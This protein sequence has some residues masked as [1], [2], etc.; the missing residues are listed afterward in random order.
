MRQRKLPLASRARCSGAA[1]MKVGRGQPR[2]QELHVLVHGPV[3][4]LVGLHRR[5]ERA[6]GDAPPISPQA[7]PGVGLGRGGDGA[8]PLP[9][10]E[11]EGPGDAWVGAGLHHRPPGLGDALLQFPP[12][13]R[14]T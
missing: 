6:E 3:H 8:Q 13:P 2:P 1:F 14:I 7:G 12:K 5:E 4:L 10:K 11:V 9:A